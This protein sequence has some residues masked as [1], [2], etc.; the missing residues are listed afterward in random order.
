MDA[1]YSI[2]IGRQ[3]GSGGRIIAKLL[4][5]E[6]HINYYDKKLLKSASEDTGFSEE[7]FVKADEETSRKRL[8]PLILSHL[9]SGGYSNNYMSNESIFKMQSDVIRNIHSKEDCIFIGRCAGYIL[10]DSD[11]ALNIFLTATAEDRIARICQFDGC[12]ESQARSLI[13]D[14]DRKRAAYFNY[15]T[16]RKWG[17]ASTYDLC[18]STS[19]FGT[20]RCAEIILDIARRKLNIEQ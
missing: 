7:F 14:A 3:I 19:V 9:L 13:E 10:R 16:G 15:F 2:N 17:D 18:L 8:R 11:R 12:T 1:H 20:E 4:A 5:D 6:L